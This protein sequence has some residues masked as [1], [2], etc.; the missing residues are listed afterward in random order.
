MSDPFDLDE[1]ICRMPNEFDSG[2]LSYETINHLIG[3]LVMQADERRRIKNL[4]PYHLPGYMN[5]WVLVDAPGE[6]HVRLHQILRSDHDR[7]PHNHPWSYTT[8]ILDGGYTEITYEVPDGSDKTP[9]EISREWRGVGEI[10]HYSK[11]HI[12]RLE[13]PPGRTCTTLFIT[14]PKEQDWGFFTPDGFVHHE[15]YLRSRGETVII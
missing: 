10:M 2:F 5:R 4:P 14:A 13:L 9:V 1:V 8:L 15:V 3:M 7:W 12:H 6:P 11:E